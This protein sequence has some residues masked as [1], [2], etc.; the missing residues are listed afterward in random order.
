MP[1]RSLVV[2][3]WPLGTRCDVMMELLTHLY[4]S[5][6]FESHPSFKGT[7]GYARRVQTIML[8]G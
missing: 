2:S 5:D 3:A 8:V 4:F 7:L 1:A 6:S